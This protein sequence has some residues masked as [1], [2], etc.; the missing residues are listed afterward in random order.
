MLESKPVSMQQA[1]AVHQSA[2]ADCIACK[3]LSLPS[4]HQA[5][6]PI[7]LTC[8]PHAKDRI[9]TPAKTGPGI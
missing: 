2:K 5:A 8:N 1:N 4:G 6:L 9:G 7:L 3:V